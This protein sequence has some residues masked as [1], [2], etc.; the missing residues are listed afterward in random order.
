MRHLLGTLR[1]RLVTAAVAGA[2]AALALAVVN[3]FPSTVLG[4]TAPQAPGESGQAAPGGS[5]TVGG[6]TVQNQGGQPCNVQSNGQTLTIACPAGFTVNVQGASCSPVGGQTNVVSC[7]V[8]GVR[9]VS[10]T[11]V[12]GVTRQATPAPAPA[13]SV[14]VAPA[15]AQPAL[16]R[17]GA[18]LTASGVNAALALALLALAAT[19]GAG[20]LALSARRARR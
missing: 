19:L 17:T 5:A 18:G 20:T 12:A 7:N 9:S 8:Q 11:T 15:A 2:L 13:P 10:F 6:V 16:P 4:Q 14:A 1:G 3:P